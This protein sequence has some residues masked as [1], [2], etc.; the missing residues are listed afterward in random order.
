MTGPG[1]SLAELYPGE[2]LGADDLALT[3]NGEITL[4]ISHLQPWVALRV[5]NGTEEKHLLHF[6]ELIA[7]AKRDGGKAKKLVL[8]KTNAVQ[9]AELHGKDAAGWAGKRITLFATT[10]RAFGKTVDCI[11]V[12]DKVPAPKQKPE[13]QT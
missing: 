2:Y 3:P 13:N 4:T 7:K 10:C 6:K 11:R 8:N 1:M 5:E 12:R 9:I